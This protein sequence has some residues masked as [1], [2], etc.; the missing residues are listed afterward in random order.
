MGRAGSISHH[1]YGVSSSSLRRGPA[2]P[3]ACPYMLGMSGAGPSSPSPSPRRLGQRPPT[4]Q[5]NEDRRE[6]LSGVHTVGSSKARTTLCCPS[7]RSYQG[8]PPTPPGLVSDSQHC[9]RPP[10]RGYPHCT[11]NNRVAWPGVRLQP[12]QRPALNSCGRPASRGRGRGEDNPPSVSAAG[13][14]HMVC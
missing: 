14:Q 4:S 2:A 10:G 12:T 5:G 6:V 3:M 13:A 11:C 9:T 8:S 7:F 1:G